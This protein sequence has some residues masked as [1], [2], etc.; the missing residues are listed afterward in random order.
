MSKVRG[1]KATGQQAASSPPTADERLSAA[2]R[3][4]TLAFVLFLSLYVTQFYLGEVVPGVTGFERLAMLLLPDQIIEQWC[5]SDFGRVHIMDRV[6]LFLVAGVLWSVAGLLGQSILQLLRVG[7]YLDCIEAWTLGLGLGLQ[8]VS[9]F[10]LAVGLAGGL[11]NPLWF[12]LLALAAVGATAMRIWQARTWSVLCVGTR[13]PAV[14]SGDS[15]DSARERD[16]GL[17]TIRLHRWWFAAFPFAGLILLGAALPPQDFDVL[18]Y[19]LQVPKEWYQQGQVTFLGHNIYGNMPLG[20]E[21]LATQAMALMPGELSWWWGALA[22]KVAMAGF[23]LLTMVLLFAIGRR[24]FCSMA[25]MVAALLYIS[26]AWIV[27]VS[28][29][30]LN[31]GVIAYYLLASFYVARLWWDA[32]PNRENPQWG[33]LVLTGLLVGAAISCKYTSLLMVL[34]PIIIVVMIVCWHRISLSVAAVGVL[35]LAVTFSSGLWFAKNWALAGNPTYPLLFQVFGGKSRTQQKDQQWRQVHQ[36]PVD[37]SGKRYSPSQAW[38]A[39]KRFL[40]GSKWLS[41]LLVPF[42]ALLVLRRHGWSDVLYWLAMLLS[43]LVAWWLGTHRL[44]RFWVPAIPVMAL[45]AGVGATWSQDR[46]WCRTMSAVMAIGLIASFIFIVAPHPSI[47][48]N[49]LLVSLD[50][51]RDDLKMTIAPGM[52]RPYAFD[53]LRKHVPAGSR[54]LVVGDAA[55]FNLQVPA[56]LQ[57]LF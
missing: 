56:R 25:G 57:Y 35:A 21:M 1:Q 7:K 37:S 36:V 53:Y 17:D 9:L 45:L 50:Q 6:G 16:L 13:S 38:G 5:G 49:R 46:L 28:T 10:T 8:F 30:G 2:T 27:M 23:P 11:Q 19:H 39:V 14:T 22:G 51:L 44:D 12:I 20:G 26:T 31:E 18:E 33:L 52:H 40:G 54:V 24:Y 4:I 41:P 47:A 55:L 34:V 3:P 43:V 32:Q 29:N 15:V 48:D 42:M